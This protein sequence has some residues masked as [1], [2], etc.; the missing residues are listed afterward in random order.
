M[1]KKILILRF[2]SIGDIVLTTPV[3]RCIA[4][5]M[6]DAE[7]HYLTKPQY[8]SILAHNPYIHQIH[9]LDKHPVL[10][11]AELKSHNF[12]L[13]LDLHNNL[14]TAMIKAVM[15]VQAYSFPKLN[16][17]KFLKVNLGI[18]LMPDVHIVDR[19][20]QTCLPLGIHNDGEGLDYFI[21][22]VERITEFEG[23]PLQ[24]GSYYTWAIGAQHFT[25]RLPNER[26]VHLAQQLDLPVVL[27]GGKED[28][29][30]AAL[31]QKQ[32]GPNAYNACGKLT[33]NQSAWV[34]AQS[35]QLYTN[36]TGLMHIAAALKVPVISFWG[37]TIPAFGMTPYYGKYEV[38]VRII[39]NNSLNCR[40]C[41]KIGFNACP[42]KHFNCMKQLEI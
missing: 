23:L 18:D 30:N 32:L 40:P 34:V 11:A 2:S 41:S 6:P 35:K 1:A 19:Y 26:I 27:L 39:E 17:E 13:I 4:R 8:K 20:L 25:K 22:E 36:D 10:K 7:I 28:M 21:P 38:P 5:Q 42:K 14:R 37:N 15:G 3:M 29:E 33:L 9:L 31:I 24:Q 12:D 16:Y